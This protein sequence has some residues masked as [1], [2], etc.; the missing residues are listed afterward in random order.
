MLTDKIPFNKAKLEEMTNYLKENNVSAKQLGIPL[1]A[2]AETRMPMKEE[3]MT[4]ET[5]ATRRCLFA[6][7]SHM[8]RAI[9]KF[10]YGASGKHLFAKN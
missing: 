4:V 5:A 3:M 7:R 2:E 9:N 10:K 1:A 6:P 8:M